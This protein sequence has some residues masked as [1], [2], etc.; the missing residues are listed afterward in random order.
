MA[1]DL[2]HAGTGLTSLTSCESSFATAI[3]A[4]SEAATYNVSDSRYR[5]SSIAMGAAKAP[6]WGL[7][8]DQAMMKDSRYLSISMPTAPT[9]VPARRRPW[10]V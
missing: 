5:T 4:V 8:T 2:C 6:Y 3:P 1:A 9:A 7:L 10:A